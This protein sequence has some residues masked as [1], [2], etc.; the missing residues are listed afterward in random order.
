MPGRL[1]QWGLG[2]SPAA[3]RPALALG[4][5][6]AQPPLGRLAPPSK[7]QW[8]SG[9]SAG[10]SESRHVT[11]PGLPSESHSHQPGLSTGLPVSPAAVRAGAR[12]PARATLA[13][14]SALQVEGR[15]PRGA[16]VPL[17][18]ASR[19]ILVGRARAPAGAPVPGA[20]RPAGTA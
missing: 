9:W 4:A 7:F 2:A 3:G 6:A 15:P 13:R 16:P 5:V 17:E 18:S 8:C 20:R 11:G 12:T 10:E 1:S 19:F 14:G